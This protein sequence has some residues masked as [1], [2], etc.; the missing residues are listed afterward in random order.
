MIIEW[1][2]R[3]QKNQHERRKIR[4]NSR[5]T[6]HQPKPFHQPNPT[7]DTILIPYKEQNFEKAIIKITEGI[8]S[9][10]DQNATISNEILLQVPD[11]NISEWYGRKILKNQLNVH[12]TN[13]EMRCLCMKLRG[14]VSSSSN[15]SNSSSSSSF[16]SSSSSSSLPSI[17]SQSPTHAHETKKNEE[18][19]SKKYHRSSSSSSSSSH[20]NHPTSDPSNHRSEIVS[21]DPEQVSMISGKALKTLVINLRNMILKRRTGRIPLLPIKST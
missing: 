4:H 12:L 16:S 7:F 17:S 20:E 9:Y 21:S 18:S 3:T 19:S 14:E 10:L 11:E 13:Q 5:N 1:R 6:T 15:L 2:R 8:V